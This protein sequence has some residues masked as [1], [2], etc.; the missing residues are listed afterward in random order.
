LGPV[1]RERV[2]GRKDAASLAR[3]CA[4]SWG[5]RSRVVTS[6]EAWYLPYFYTEE[7]RTV[8]VTAHAHPLDPG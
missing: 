5:S 2:I 8:I 4:P 7:T 3:V 1:V 6:G